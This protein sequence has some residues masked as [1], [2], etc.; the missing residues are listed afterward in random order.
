MIS[1]LICE[2]QVAKIHQHYI[3]LMNV[4]HDLGVSIPARHT[5]WAWFWQEL[6]KKS[7]YSSTIVELRNAH[8]EMYSLQKQLAKDL[9]CACPN[10]M[11]E[12]QNAFG[13]VFE[14]LKMLCVPRTDYIGVVIGI[15]IN[16]DMAQSILQVHAN[17]IGY[18]L[19]WKEA[20][21]MIAHKSSPTN[22]QFFQTL[23]S[24]YYSLLFRG[25]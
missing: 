1:S 17:P 24:N 6:M 9:I 3:V 15:A 10:Q 25:F 11:F 8:F 4:S 16:E 12:I 13:Y 23:N 18:F 2:S 20:R 5:D 22:I 19:V 21:N 14:N 7:N